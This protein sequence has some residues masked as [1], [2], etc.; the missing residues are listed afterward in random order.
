M[1]RYLPALLAFLSLSIPSFAST[2]KSDARLIQNYWVGP[3]PQI[4][5]PTPVLA[6][7]TDI[8]PSSIFYVV[9]NGAEPS[10]SIYS[11][12]VA[13]TVNGNPIYPSVK[14][15]S[16]RSDGYNWCEI[17]GIRMGK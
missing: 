9:M 7:T 3:W 4:T 10:K 13:A 12:V 14:A 11:T 17:D 8:E 15:C 16:V 1:K 5:S 6:I 2:W